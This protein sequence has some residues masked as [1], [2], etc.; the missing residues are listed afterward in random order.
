M[1]LAGNKRRAQE[2]GNGGTFTWQEWS[3]LK[4][5]FGHTC[6]ACLRAEPDIKLTID[7]IVPIV[8]GGAHSRENIQPLCRQCNRRKYTKTIRYAPA[9]QAVA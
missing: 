2:R 7:H 3:D 6:P 1:R 4:A 8:K 5:A 9:P